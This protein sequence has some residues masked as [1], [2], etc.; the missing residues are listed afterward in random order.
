MAWLYELET[1][2]AE[3]TGQMH[4]SM[5]DWHNDLGDV[6]LPVELLSSLTIKPETASMYRF[7]DTAEWL[8]KIV[9]GFYCNTFDVNLP[10]NQIAFCQNGTAAIHLVVRA[11]V[12]KGMKRALVITP[13]YFSLMSSL[14]Q[15]GVATVY[16][17][18]DLFNEL[19]IDTSMIIKEARHQMVQAIFITAPIFSTGKSFNSDALIQILQYTE[20]E[21]LFLVIDEMLAGLPW[22]Q[23][24]YEPYLS[25]SMRLSIQSKNCLYI[26]SLT[27][28]LFINGIKHSIVVG[29]SEL[30]TQIERKSD[31]IMGGI[32]IYQMELAAKIYSCEFWR[33]VYQAARINVERFCTT[34]D[35]CKSTI[36]ETS[37]KITSAESGFHCIAFIPENC[38]APYKSAKKIVQELMFEYGYSAIP[39]PHFGF[40]SFSPLGF[41]INLSKKP[42]KLY[43]ALKSLA[44]IIN[45]NS[46]LFNQ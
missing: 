33:S 9:S 36:I 26:F 8:K 29:N 34:Y 5:S 16:H 46:D 40:P 30:I 43:S 14:E 15:C 38:V 6:V 22:M 23:Q 37:L 24:D 20:S 25:H 44:R 32:T 31:H 41:R 42:G 21:G 1:R 39:L 17:H 11:L 28:S 7:L 35:L 27:K 10:Y 4:W 18:L 3:E 13:V 2:Y 12:Q 19:E 45:K